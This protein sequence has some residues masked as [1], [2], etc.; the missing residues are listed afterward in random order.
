MRMLRE[1][2]K[3]K[4]ASAQRIAELE[5][6]LQ[7][8][9]TLPSSEKPPKVH[10]IDVSN[11]SPKEVAPAIEKARVRLDNDSEPVELSFVPTNT[12]EV[13]SPIKVGAI[14]ILTTLG[15]WAAV[16][17]LALLAF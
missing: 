2:E 13:S 8:S 16:I 3:E 9:K 11:L 17:S 15:L 14:I 4:T 12:G 5:K 1:A 6:Q 7:N 10:Y